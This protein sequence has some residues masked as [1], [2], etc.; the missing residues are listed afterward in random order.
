M[1]FIVEIPS[2]FNKSTQIPN[3]LG[4]TTLTGNETIHGSLNVGG[5]L[6]LDGTNNITDKFTS[7]IPVIFNDTTNMLDVSGQNMDLSGNLSVAGVTA[8]YMD[9][10]GSLDV[11]G[12]TTIWGTL[13]AN[14]GITCDTD[15]FVVEDATGN[16]SIGGTLDVETSLTTNQLIVNDDLYFDTIVIRRPTGTTYNETDFIIALMELQCWVNGTNIMING[17]IIPYFA[18][19]TNK[20]VDVG[21]YLSVTN[22]NNNNIETGSGG[23]HSPTD[24]DN[25]NISLIC[26]EIPRTKIQDIQSIV[27]YNRSFVTLDRA[28]GLAI[29]LYNSD[30]DPNLETPLATTNVI[31][32][33]V[34]VYRY[35]FPAIDAYPSGDFSDTNSTTN[36]ASETLALKEVVSEFAESAN[37]VGGLKVDTITTTGNVDIS[38]SLT[39]NSLNINKKSIVNGDFD[40]DTIV[41]RRPTGVGTGRFTGIPQVQLFVNN[42]N[43]LPDLV[44][45]STFKVDG[46][47][48]QDISNIP[49]F[50]DW[51]DKTLAPNLNTAYASLVV[52]EVIEDGRAYYGII[53]GVT[54]YNTDVG[55]YI[56]MSDKINIKDIQSAIIYNRTDGNTNFIACAIELY[57]R[58]NDPNLETPLSSTN[59]IT[60]VEDVYRFDYP[61]IDTYPSGDFSDTDSISQIASETLALKDVVSEFAG[62]VNIAGGLNVDTITLKD[63][64]G[65]SGMIHMNDNRMYFLSRA[66]NSEVWTQVNGQWPLI[67]HTDTNLAQFGGVISAPNQVRFK[68][69]RTASTTIN[70]NVTL[71]FNKTLENVGGGYSNSTYTFTAPITGTYYFYAQIFTSEDNKFRAD[72][73]TGSTLI[74]RIGREG[75]GSGRGGPTSFVGFFHYTL[76][77]GQTMYMKRADGIVNLPVYPYCAFGG[78]LLG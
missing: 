70:T 5:P 43:V 17:D 55:L 26:K 3:R 12:N 48:L 39:C 77:Q 38:G 32:S 63:T 15:K 11:S 51:S 67:L 58:S 35:D 52:D 13:Q 65:R 44:S 23:A 57:N 34:D 21:S 10:S 64:D 76:N 73:Y 50:I 78:Y 28:N 71:P 36:I 60:T 20:D 46:T 54:V 30:N 47:P 37:I 62:S 1:S 9:L 33:G 18:E 49:F 56:P 69:S 19:F 66:T 61:A 68:A 14:G 75:P 31:T 29:E 16:T 72:F 59:L 4:N 74:Q 45:Q 40:F 53:D 42:V 6:T 25:E 2:V 22:I 27:L 24:Y 41:I 8:Q 7:N